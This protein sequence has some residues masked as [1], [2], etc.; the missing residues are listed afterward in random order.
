[1]DDLANRKAPKPAE[2]GIA[3]TRNEGLVDTRAQ[4]PSPERAP[5]RPLT[6]KIR[7]EFE[8]PAIVIF[9]HGVLIVIGVEFLSLL[10]WLIE[11]SFISDPTKNVLHRL[12]EYLMVLAFALLGLGFIIKIAIVVWGGILKGPRKS[13]G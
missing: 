9:G 2:S 12:D 6:H 8:E 7:E 3:I 10:A 4:V 5:R 11:H 13:D 1:M